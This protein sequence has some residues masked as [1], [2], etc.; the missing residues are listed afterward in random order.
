MDSITASSLGKVFDNRVR[1]LDDLSL[2]IPAGTIFGFLGPNGSGKTTTIRLLNGIL[3]PTAGSATVMGMDSVRDR[4]R[5]RSRAGVMTESAA[6]YENLTG[7]ENLEFFGRLYDLEADK[8]RDR[9]KKMLEDFGL[10]EASNRRVRTYSTGM[11]KKL[12]LAAC[13][14]HEPQV[15]FLDEPTNGLDPEAA[16][17]VTDLIQELAK[18]RGVTVFL[19]THQLRYFEDVCDLFGFLNK[20]RLAALGSLKTLLS[21]IEGS[22]LL[23][24]RGTIKNASGYTKNTDGSYSRKIKDD[25][26]ASQLIASLI[27]DSARLFEARQEHYSLEDLYRLHIEKAREADHA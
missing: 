4:E 7:I 18:S 25:D 1:A 2:S 6:L 22:L 13:L 21:D 27:Q 16:R 19:S 20:G 8:I 3:E 5:I 11:K 17:G 9:S 24:V 23:R 26:E 14:L 12:S 15:L 10:A